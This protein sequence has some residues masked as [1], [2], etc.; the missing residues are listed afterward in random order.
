V[1]TE[2]GLCVPDGVAVLAGLAVQETQL[3][4]R[5]A[6]DVFPAHFE[7]CWVSWIEGVSVG[8]CEGIIASKDISMALGC[9]AGVSEV[10]RGVVSSDDRAKVLAGLRL[11]DTGA[12][13]STA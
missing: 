11:R 1:S 4:E 8:V 2:A 9:P 10:D 12:T 5:F 3:L 7:G 6:E 13:S